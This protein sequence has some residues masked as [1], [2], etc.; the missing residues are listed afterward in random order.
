MYSH[1]YEFLLSVESLVS[2]IRILVLIPTLHIIKTSSNTDAI[3]ISS[4]LYQHRR[5]VNITF[6]SIT[7]LGLWSLPFGIV[8]AAEGKSRIF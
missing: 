2:R 3:D 4:R 7:N 6:P 1:T 8:H 5:T